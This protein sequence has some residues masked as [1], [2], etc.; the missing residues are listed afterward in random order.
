MLWGQV[1]KLGKPPIIHVHVNPN[2]AEVGC[3]CTTVIP[4]PQPV[5]CMQPIAVLGASVNYHKIS[6]SIFVQAIFYLVHDP[7]RT[8]TDKGGMQTD[9]RGAQGPPCSGCGGGTQLPPLTKGLG[10]NESWVHQA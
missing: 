6:I 7:A 9:N 8:I 4:G 1:R 5:F 2:P 10:I 3:Q